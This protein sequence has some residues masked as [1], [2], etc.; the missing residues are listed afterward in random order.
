MPKALFQLSRPF[1]LLAPAVG[2]VAGA[3]VATAAT[4]RDMPGRRLALA[5]LTAL[6][7]TAASN[8]WNQIFDLSIDRINKPARPLPSGA[9]SLRQALVFGHATALLGLA[10]AWWVGPGFFACVA[11]GVF[12]TW[13]YSAPPLRT[14]RFTGAALLTIAIPRGLLVPVAGWS[15][16]AEPRGGEPWALGI[17]SGLF[18]LG[19]AVTKDFAD[20]TGDEQHACE[21]LPIRVGVRTAARL[22]AP[23]LVLPFLLYPLFG[24]LGWLQPPVPSLWVLAASLAA[25]GLFAAASLVRNPEGMAGGDG[26]HPAWAAMYLLLLAMHIG[27]AIVYQTQV[28]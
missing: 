6:L 19:A 27:C 14:K 1:T 9:L 5:V 17:I 12:A 3:Y 13:I 26:N 25:L 11:A 7:V 15:V 2:V 8:A 4:H 21:T 24:A 10:G 20:V 28:A 23:F 22:V 18:V 16:V